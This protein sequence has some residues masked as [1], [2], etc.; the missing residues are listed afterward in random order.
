MTSRRQA[1]VY[2]CT[3]T[4][5]LWDTCILVP[6]RLLGFV[7][8]LATILCIPSVRRSNKKKPG[9]IHNPSESTDTT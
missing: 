8:V 7:L 1:K 6:D 3:I 2:S 9:S 4:A 5:V